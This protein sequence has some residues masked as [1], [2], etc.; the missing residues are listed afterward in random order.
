MSGGLV[1]FVFIIG[2]AVYLMMN[3]TLMFWFVVV[4]VAIL[5]LVGYINWLRR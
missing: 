4:P 2:G 5:L 1:L 3:H